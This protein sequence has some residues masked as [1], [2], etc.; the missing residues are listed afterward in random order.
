VYAK[1]R[2]SQESKSLRKHV[3][4]ADFT[5]CYKDYYKG[6][7]ATDTYRTSVNRVKAIQVFCLRASRAES[8]STDRYRLSRIFDNISFCQNPYFGQQT[9]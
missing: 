7:N 3:Q 5:S 8:P 1:Q 6:L 9:L 2:T 4:F